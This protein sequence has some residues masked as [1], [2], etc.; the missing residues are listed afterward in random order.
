[1]GDDTALE[2]NLYQKGEG[3]YNAGH[4]DFG[5]DADDDEVRISA[6]IKE[7]ALEVVPF[8][9]VPDSMLPFDPDAVTFDKSVILIRVG[10]RTPID[11]QAYGASG[12][13]PTGTDD[14]T[15]INAAATAADA[16]GIT[17]VFHPPA[18]Y[19]V[20][21]DPTFPGNTT[22]VGD[23]ASYDGSA[24]SIPD[25]V[26]EAAVTQHEAAL[27]IAESQI[28]DGSILARLAAAETVTGQWTFDDKIL[29]SD[30]AD[31]ANSDQAARPIIHHGTGSASAVGIDGAL[32]TE[33]V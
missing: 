18:V 28:P 22:P 3:V 31:A 25:H 6:A 17:G 21:S 33:D 24:T 4:N 30:T 1:M 27:S 15:A 2:A 7:A 20:S 32:H 19:T 23:A 16:H 26:P 9:L 14:L 29:F 8:V 11:V 12:D 13:G 5:F 10:Q